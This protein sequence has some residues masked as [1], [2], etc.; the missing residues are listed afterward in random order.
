MAV[1]ARLWDSGRSFGD[2]QQAALTCRRH[3]MLKAAAR[4]MVVAGPEREIAN[5][6]ITRDHESLLVVIVCVPGQACARLA[7]DQ[8][9]DAAARRAPQDF[10]LDA[11]GNSFPMS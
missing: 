8:V 5:G 9:G 6:D 7:A 3:P 10:S 2:Q 1:A 4:Q 11:A